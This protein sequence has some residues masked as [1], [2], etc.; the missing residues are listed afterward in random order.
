MRQIF[1][2]ARVADAGL[3]GWL[4]DG[5]VIVDGATID[6]VAR[7]SELPSDV[8]TSSVVHELGDVSILPG[9]IETHAHL[10]FAAGPDYRD[11]ARPEPV[12]PMLIRATGHARTLLLAGTTTARD[13]GSRTEVALA[14]RDAIRDG[15]APP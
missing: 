13:T 7:R 11:L 8:A 6:A 5:A 12:E 3:D 9:F 14:I 10:H 2:G 4:D 1:L 15:T